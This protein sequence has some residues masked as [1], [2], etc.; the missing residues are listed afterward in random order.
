M[1]LATVV[2]IALLLLSAVRT[3]PAVTTPE[4]SPWAI[5]TPELS[6]VTPWAICTASNET[7][8]TSDC[9]QVMICIGDPSTAYLPTVVETCDSST[10]CSS[11]QAACVAEQDSDCAA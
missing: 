1:E 9:S 8:C 11:E 2:Q 4:V 3:S 10:K 5:T 7:I 6:T